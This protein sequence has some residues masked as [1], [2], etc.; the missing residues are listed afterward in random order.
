MLALG[1][2]SV[3]VGRL[4]TVAD[5]PAVGGTRLMEYEPEHTVPLLFAHLNSGLG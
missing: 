2:V 3:S 1:R 4:P 5:L